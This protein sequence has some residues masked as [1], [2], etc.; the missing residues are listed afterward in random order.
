[1]KSRGSGRT[2]PL[3]KIESVSSATLAGWAVGASGAAVDVR[4]LAGTKTVPVQVRRVDR[5]DVRAAHPAKRAAPDGFVVELD[6]EVW[7]PAGADGVVPLTVFLDAIEFELP[8]P[9]D[10]SLLDAW[11][12]QLAAEAPSDE[13][14]R[15]MLRFLAHAV[16]AGGPSRLAAEVAPAV[17]REM[18]ARGLDAGRDAAPGLV[19]AARQQARLEGFDGLVL[20]GWACDPAL[21]PQVFRVLAND[22]EVTCRV[23]R[24]DRLDVQQALGMATAGFGFRIELPPEVWTHADEAGRCMLDVFVEGRHLTPEPVLLDADR[25]RRLASDAPAAWSPGASTAAAL[26]RLALLEQHSDALGERGW[27]TDSDRAGVAAWVSALDPAGRR[28]DSGALAADQ[29]LPDDGFW[30]ALESSADL[31]LSGWVLDE[32]AGGELFRLVCNGHDVPF[33][34]LRTHRSDVGKALGLAS[35]SDFLGFEV[36][37]PAEIWRHADANGACNVALLVNQRPFPIASVRIDRA[38]LDH[39]IQ[40]RF[41][42]AGD[43][44]LRGADPAAVRGRLLTWLMMEHVAASGGAGRLTPAAQACLHRSE[45]WMALLRQHGLGGQADAPQAREEQQMQRRVWRLQRRLN[46]LLAHEGASAALG[47]VLSDIDATGAVRTQFLLSLVPLMHDDPAAIARIEDELPLDVQAW[48]AARGDNW[49]RSLYLV[50]LARKGCFADACAV[51]ERIVAA[52]AAG[53]LNT[54]CVAFAVAAALQPAA[55]EADPVGGAAKPRE[56]LLELFID[57]LEGL[58]GDYWSR[59]HDR[60]LVEAAANVVAMRGNCDE[61]LARRIR[62]AALHHY[63]LVPS[64][65]ARLDA[66]AAPVDDVLARAREDFELVRAAFDATGEAGAL[67]GIWREVLERLRVQQIVR[68]RGA[69]QCLR[70][71]MLIE[72]G[73]ARA[74]GGAEDMSWRFIWEG[75]SPEDR[76]RIDAFPLPRAGQASTPP[77]SLWPTPDAPVAAG[78]GPENRL[79]LR[80]APQRIAALSQAPVLVVCVVRNER[81]MIP[82]FLAHYRQLGARHFVFVDNGSDDGTAEYLLAQ[83]DVVLYATDTDYRDSHYGVCWQQAVLA[84]HAPGRWAVVADADELLLYRDC[85][86]V[87]LPEL[88]RRLDVL[89]HDAACVLMLDMY[90]RGALRDTDF[91]RVGPAQANWFDREPLLRWRLGTGLY[92]NAPTWLSA[93]RHRLIPHSPPNAFTAQKIALLRYRPWVRLSEGL[94]YA[95][96]LAPAAEP[97]FFGHYKYHAGFREKVL[98]EIER[99]QHYDGASEYAQYTAMIADPEASLFAPDVSVA[100]TDS[101]TLPAQAARGTDDGER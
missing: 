60:W 18:N 31:A 25:L 19:R 86:T 53:W 75:A 28:H 64:F 37:L 83:P 79:E 32:P 14:E 91:A 67:P 16:A 13:R 99:R 30:A 4:V 49:H 10:R 52:P 81:M 77:G 57:L 90:P 98:L 29:G 89:G 84:A 48:Y 73:C 45:A 78:H 27:F 56:R 101:R 24:L 46:L 47:E 26:R 15:Q 76:R 61:A 59:S 38:A 9:F 5:P 23:E 17:A 63:G 93:L 41:G 20:V 40:A 58:P 82:H 35:V 96:G 2:G 87:P 97:L 100:L 11:W 88:V 6:T 80:S 65:W 92:S 36:Q 22:V 68:R 85:E 1:M 8:R 69:A 55:G 42:P 94:H 51:L 54:E 7:A 44:A 74:A 33:D 50:G 95:T 21:E 72:L 70:E 3:G 71:L 39:A 66:R 62:D 43:R 34:V 12:N